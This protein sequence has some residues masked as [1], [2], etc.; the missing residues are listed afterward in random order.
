MYRKK[1]LLT[2]CILCVSLCSLSGCDSTPAERVAAVKEMVSQAAAV[3][4]A[5]DVVIADLEKTIAET[6]AAL[7][8]PNIP[9]DIKLE[10][11]NVLA[12]ASAKLAGLKVEKQK[13]TAI[14]TRWQTFLEQVDPNNLTLDQEL[15]LYATGAGDAA[16]F[17][18][19]PYRGYIYLGLV[20]V[21]L[22]GSVVK[23]ISQ[24]KQ[25]NASKKTVTEIIVSV[26]RLLGSNQVQD[27]GGAK[28][29]L[30]DNQSGATQDV[31]DAIHNP[32]ENTAPIK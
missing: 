10:L 15:Q 19:Q 20:L 18:P 13:A 3:S 16:Q 31:V 12:G 7:Q 25:V 24:W 4:Q 32:M 17:L 11:E 9:P 22:L 5:A 2:V 21:P 29:I 1:L 27:A 6:Q 26:D 8:N 28:F 14:I 30:Q 23:N